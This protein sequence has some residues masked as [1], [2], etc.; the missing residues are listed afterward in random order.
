M[1]SMPTHRMHQLEPTVFP[2]ASPLSISVTSRP[3]AIYACI[4]NIWCKNKNIIIYLIPDEAAKF[5]NDEWLI[6]SAVFETTQ[7]IKIKKKN[8]AEVF[9]WLLYKRIF[10]EINFR[11]THSWRVSCCWQDHLLDSNQRWVS[12]SPSRRWCCG[13]KSDGSCRGL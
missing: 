2:T 13:K 7:Y 5:S 4:V 8:L 9:W 12:D 6:F 3:H 1:L 10:S 11:L